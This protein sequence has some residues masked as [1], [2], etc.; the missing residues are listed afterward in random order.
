MRKGLL[1]FAGIAVLAGGCKKE[2]AAPAKA[3]PAPAPAPIEISISIS[4]GAAGSDLQACQEATDAWS[5]KTGHK[6]KIV[7]APTDVGQQLTLFQ[8]LLTAKS[9]DIDVFRIDVIWPGIL[10]NHFIDL[11]GEIPQD[12]IDQHFK[13]IVENNT[14]NGRLVGLPWFT[15]AGLLFYRKDLLEKY[16]QKPPTTWEELV[17]TAKLIVEKER[18]AGNPKLVGFVFQAKASES[19]TCDALEWVDA[20]GGGTIVDDTGKITINN[21]KAIEAIRFASSL[22]GTVAPEGVLN[23]DEEGARGVFQ[24][25]L[26]V[27][28]RN[29]PYAWAL[30]NSDD[31]PIKGKIGVMALPKGGEGGKATGTLGGWQLAVSKYSKNPKIAADLVMF[32]A[33]PEE[34]KRRA[35]TASFN[36]TIA[37]LY[38]DPEILAKNPFMGQLYDTFTNAVARPSKVTGVKYSQVSAAFRDRVHSVLSKKEKPEAAMKALEEDLTRL[39]AGGW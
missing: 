32:L 37:S 30:G 38:K 24:S 9:P 5:K 14:V 33:S 3:E 27:F 4:C 25:G 16:N 15:D 21:P 11:K 13:P 1:L 2:E 28:M 39:S 17:K 19:L 34:Q 35:L 22:V 29:W 7:T 26:A 36:P 20:F 23:Y 31:S 10:G 12:V 8:Q 6:V 18:K